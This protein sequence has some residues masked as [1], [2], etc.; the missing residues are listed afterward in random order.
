MKTTDYKWLNFNLELHKL[1]ERSKKLKQDR[2]NFY[3]ES[4]IEF[5]NGIKYHKER[6]DILLGKKVEYPLVR[7]LN[8]T[9]KNKWIDF[10]KKS[11]KS[12]C[13]FID[14]YKSKIKEVA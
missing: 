12:C 5:E 11:I 2:L 1:K 14:D 7:R 9:L 8:N 10:H 13:V 6:L 4:I 3:N